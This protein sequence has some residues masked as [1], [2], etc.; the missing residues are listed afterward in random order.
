[1][2]AILLIFVLRDCAIIPLNME[3]NHTSPE[4]Y[5]NEIWVKVA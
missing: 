4:A 5:F 1:M 3:E 2:A